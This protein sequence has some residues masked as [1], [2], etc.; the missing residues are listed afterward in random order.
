MKNFIVP[1]ILNIIPSPLVQRKTK[2]FSFLAGPIESQI[3]H[4]LFYWMGHIE[5]INWTIYSTICLMMCCDN[6]LLTLRMHAH[7]HQ[8]KNIIW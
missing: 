3:V 1:T 4:V 6:L 5:G 2:G 8:Q 7:V